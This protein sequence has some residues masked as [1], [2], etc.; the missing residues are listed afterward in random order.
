M[1]THALKKLAE[2]LLSGELSI[3]QFVGR[4]YGNGI[5]DTGEAQVDLDRPCRCGFPEVI[6]AQGKTVEA[7]E[8]IFHILIDHG[9]DVLATRMS[10]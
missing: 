5:A 3:G 1:N 10:A 6:F 8:K 4:L 7:I 2:Q 9:V